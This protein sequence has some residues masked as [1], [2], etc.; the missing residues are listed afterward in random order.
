MTSPSARP[1]SNLPADLTTFV[2]RRHDVIAVRQL[3][4]VSRLVTLTGIGG[5]GKTRLAL[6]A[7]GE[8]CRA[9]PDGVFLV[10]LAS[11]SGPELLPQAVIDALGI[12]EQPAKEPV[13]VIG[14]HLRGRRALLV[15][16]SCEHLV[17]A[18]GDL[19]DHILRADSGVRILATSQHA[20]RIAGEHIYPVSPLLVPDPGDRLKPGTA[21]HYPSVTLF[22]DRAA[23]VVPGFAVTPDN[24]AAVIR[25]CHRLE[26][27]PLALELASVRLRVLTLEE[28]A[29][30]LDDRFQMLRE[31]NRNLPRRHRTLRALIDWSYELCTPIEQLLWARTTVFA[32]GFT[33]VAL[34]ETCSDDA[35][36]RTEI[37]DTL[38]RLVDKSVLIRVEERGN[39]R[40]RMLD[41]LRDYGH[42]RLVEAGDAEMMA[43]RHRDWYARLMAT[44]GAEWSGPRQAEWATRLQLEHTNLRH[45]LEY[46]MAT[47]GEAR[48]GLEM[49]AV[50]WFWGAMDHLGE[51]CHWLDRGLALHREPTTTRVWAMATAAYMDAFQGNH[52]RM[53]QRAEA[54]HALAVELGDPRTL[55]YANHVL[56]F[57]L[58]WTRSGLTR[59]VVL[60]ARALEQYVDGGFIAQQYID[61]LLVEFATTHILLGHNETAA[62]LTDQLYQGC[63][64]AG[65]HWNLSYA[66]WLRGLL[67]VLGGDPDRAEE[68][69]AEALRI[70]RPFRDTMGLALTL[71]V[72]A[73][74]AALRGEGERA[75]QLLGGTDQIWHSLGM[76]QLRGLR[77][78]YER[79]ARTAVGDARFDGAV[80]R[81]TRL[82]VDELVAVGLRERLPVA[83][84][85]VVSSP[86]RL[87][88]REREVA[89]LVATGM[90]NKEIA[91]KLVIS[92]RTAEG[93][94]ERT[95]TKLGFNTRTQIAT[96]VAT[97]QS[98]RG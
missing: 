39:V 3:F 76:R 61:T 8:M 64:A 51:A 50:P 81:G 72:A 15:L 14:E 1:S 89:E 36:P 75:G 19:A 28:L 2:G 95:L 7:A 12:R 71:E 94:V 58:S 70:K 41:T 20:L 13:A 53:H 67:S 10:Q 68:E 48:I 74:A 34:E 97:Q 63:H 80:E 25:L 69:L 27:I 22:A 84:P 82:G 93:H 9:F 73:W 98:S 43:R 46:C 24:E 33:A 32:D 86:V 16:D 21:A 85:Q 56:G 6:R 42:E 38:A 37:L 47:P 65:E 78:G 30:R 5:V 29:T 91:A 83:E 17:D 23:A 4:S 55:A 87:T 11:L 79:Q 96:W 54:A 57:S 45:A 59:A 31:G 90:S 66:H 18:T 88:R 92:L 52:V 40:F 77:P 62:G 49:A 44:A 26:G 35:L 60:L